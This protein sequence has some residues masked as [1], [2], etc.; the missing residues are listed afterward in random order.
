MLSVFQIVYITEETCCIG[1]LIMLLVSIVLRKRK[2]KLIGEL[3]AMYSMMVLW[4]FSEILVYLLEGC[5]QYI[6]FLRALDTV[7]YTF[8]LGSFLFF[9]VYL[10]KLVRY[11]TGKETTVNYKIFIF[12][13]IGIGF[14]YLL[15]HLFGW[16]MYYDETG[17]FVASKYYSLV[18][19]PLHVVLLSGILMLILYHRM[20]TLIQFLSLAFF[21]CL[22]EVL[23]LL[24]NVMPFS[25]VP[26]ASTLGGVFQYVYLVSE[27]DDE[28]IQL[29]KELTEQ[30]T[31]VI[32]SQIQPHFLY[33]SLAAISTLCLLE[34]A[35]TPRIAI[36]K[37]ANYLRGNLEVLKGNSMVHFDKELDHIQTYLW[38]EKMRFQDDLEVVYDIQ[39]RNFLLP[40]LLIQP[41]V[42]NAVK[43]G[44]C[45]K[46]HG[47]TVTI[48]TRREKD[49]VY[50]T[51]ADTGVGFD[52]N[53]MPE[54]G[55]LH[56][57]LENTM[58]RIKNLCH[59]S[60]LVESVLGERTTV[61]IFLP[62]K[63]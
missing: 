57:G 1:F 59:G 44:I 13:I 60:M 18:L 10:L 48:S 2:K 42:E 5:P 23:V 46:E 39:E 63:G 14:L 9:F 51:V 37:F 56:V 26:L 40:S 58:E 25:L 43:H 11:K 38:L 50:I 52:T 3:S 8:S 16:I 24:G 33:N 30:K 49:G 20:F 34:N 15:S 21:L 4:F 35:E 61:T 7:A 17:Y 6:P 12:I 54:D 45:Q 53:A 47:G 19:V 32:L 62:E 31:Q 36:E 27:M 55:K 29:D 28:V 41:L 22:P